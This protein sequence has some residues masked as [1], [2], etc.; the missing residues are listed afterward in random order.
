MDVLNNVTN[1]LQ[2]AAAHPFYPLEVEIAGYL[3]NEYSVLVLL[4]IFAAWLAVLL[5]ATRIITK[6]VQPDIAPTELLTVMWFVMSEQER[7]DTL[8]RTMY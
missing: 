8:R 5:G 4:S 3:A 6:R 1:V 7:L 2:H